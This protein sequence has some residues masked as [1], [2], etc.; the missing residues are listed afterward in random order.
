MKAT[1]QS[2]TYCQG[3]SEIVRNYQKLKKTPLRFHC[4]YIVRNADTLTVF[5]ITLLLL[6]QDQKVSMRL[7]VDKTSGDGL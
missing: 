6:F 4:C 7:S 3:L 1:L 2:E 5:T